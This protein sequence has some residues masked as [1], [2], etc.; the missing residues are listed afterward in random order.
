MTTPHYSAKLL[1]QSWADDHD[2]PHCSLQW[3]AVP[4]TQILD[5]C[6]LATLADPRGYWGPVHRY[7]FCKRSAVPG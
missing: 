5:T 7:I 2:D 3:L 4:C 1:V 6:Q